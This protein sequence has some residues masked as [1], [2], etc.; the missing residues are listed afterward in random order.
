MQAPNRKVGAS[1]AAGALSILIVGA[2]AMFGIVLPVE[3]ASGLTTL[4]M[5]G[6]G[7]LVPEKDL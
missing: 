6:V 2:L 7:Y 5:F 1:A 3:M 4:L